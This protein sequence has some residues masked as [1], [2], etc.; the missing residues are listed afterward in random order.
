MG[1]IVLATLD[2]S[3]QVS[4]QIQGRDPFFLLMFEE[5]FPDQRGFWTIDSLRLFV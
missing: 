4:S 1:Q 5:H 3:A 2:T